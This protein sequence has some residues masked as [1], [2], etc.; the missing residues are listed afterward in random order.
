MVPL[1]PVTSTA[2][3]PGS[4]QELPAVP[5]AASILTAP[6]SE[7]IEAPVPTSRRKKPRTRIERPEVNGPEVEI[8]QSIVGI[9]GEEESNYFLNA[10]KRLPISFETTWSNF[11]NR[12]ITT[13][14][15]NADKWNRLKVRLLELGAI[16][17]DAAGNIKK[18]F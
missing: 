5:T 13:R 14:H 11:A 4:S 7:P 12:H 3:I 10:L 1:P 17:Q 18:S 9:Y 15:R 2:S 16:E 6:A 8:L